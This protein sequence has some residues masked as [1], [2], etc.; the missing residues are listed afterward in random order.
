M[1]L[2]PVDFLSAELV[3]HIQKNEIANR[4]IVDILSAS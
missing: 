2:S 4:A 3:R 1:P